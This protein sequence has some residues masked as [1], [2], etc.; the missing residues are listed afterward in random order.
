MSESGRGKQHSKVWRTVPMLI[1]IS[2]I[3]ICSGQSVRKLHSLSRIDG[4]AGVPVLSSTEMASCL[5]STFSAL[6]TLPHSA[7]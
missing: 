5:P 6:R 3:W 4:R 1:M 2:V 7:M